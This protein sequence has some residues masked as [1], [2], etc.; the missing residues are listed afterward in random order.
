MN[1]IGP[2]AR[3]LARRWCRFRTNSNLGS[4][5][6]QA[7]P[8]HTSSSRRVRVT[9]FPPSFSLSSFLDTVHHGPLQSVVEK[10]VEQAVELSFLD[11]RMAEAFRR[12]EVTYSDSKLTVSALPEELLPALLVANIGE[13]GNTRT[14][15]ATGF[16][17][18]PLLQMKKMRTKIQNLLIEAEH[19]EQ[20]GAELI[21]SCFSISDSTWVCALFVQPPQLI[22]PIVK[23]PSIQ[24]LGN[25]EVTSGL[26]R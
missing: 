7:E 10:K 15:R 14:L 11:W 4:S 9:G 6:T 22:V 26:H 23:R 21:I 18:K 3:P 20:R 19:I 1:I 5:Q 12:S 16:S 2:R 24:D 25:H 13:S 17:K 8:N